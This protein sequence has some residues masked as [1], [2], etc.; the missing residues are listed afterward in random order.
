MKKTRLHVSAKNVGRFHGDLLVYCLLQSKKGRVKFGPGLKQS[1]QRARELGDFKAKQG[2]KFIFYPEKS[3]VKDLPAP[4]RIL[5]IG[6]GELKKENT[7]YQLKEMIRIGGGTVA[8]EVGRLKAKNVMVVLPSITGLSVRQTASSLTEG[9]LLGDYRFTKYK[10]AED[11]NSVFEGIEDLSYFSSRSHSDVRKGMKEGQI[12]AMSGHL[13]RDMAH[14]PANKWTPDSFAKEGRRIAR[15]YG[16]KCRVLGKGDMKRLGMGGIIGVNQ[17][18]ALPPKMVIVE[19][20]PPQKKYQTLLLVG[21]GL[22]FDSGGVSIKPAAGMEDMKYDMCGGA[23]VLSCMLAVG[24]LRPSKRVIGMVPAT[25]NMVSGSAIKPGDI[26]R[27]YNGLSSEVVNTDAEGRM[28]LADALAYGVKKYKPDCVVD[29]ATLTGAVI[30]GLGHHHTGLVSNNDKLA[31]R[32]IGAGRESGEPVWRLPLNED[33][34][35]QLKSEVADVKNIG[36]RSGGTITAAAYLEK[37]VDKTPWA[38]LDIAGTAW[39]FTKKSYIPKGPSGVG[40]RILIELIRGW[41]KL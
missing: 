9:L 29:L 26:I 1:I 37:F 4:K 24:E 14:E 23:A 18:S 16:M 5:V 27:H 21:K 11:D 19:Y 22:T 32:L 40:V 41:K 12:A 31:K 8:E 2:E 20:V 15:Q 35:E 39:N 36:G 3:N 25:E 13:A 7:R 6:L 33:Y 38:H 30:I 28:I 10:K 17:G 34:S